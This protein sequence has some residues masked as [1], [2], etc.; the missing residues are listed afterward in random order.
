MAFRFNFTGRKRVLEAEAQIHVIKEDEPPGQPGHLKVVLE[1]TFTS[2][3]RHIYDKSDIVMLEAIRRTKLRRCS[4]GT[5][6]E[7]QKDTIADFPDFPNGKEVYYRL[8]IVDPVTHKLKGL[9]KTLKDADREQKPTDVESLL[10]VERSQDDDELGNLFWK[11][12]FES[13]GPVLIISSKKFDSN[14]LVKS[15]E[16]R[17]LV[18]PEVLREVLIEAF[19]HSVPSSGDS[20]WVDNWKTFVA[21]N[22]GVEG[23]P[24][25]EPDALD[26]NYIRETKRWIDDAGR[27]FA[28]KYQLSTIERDNNGGWQ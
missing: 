6:G 7:L 3:G 18:L 15:P 2:S 25:N 24:E 13:E 26:E 22:L 19:I 9:A 16:F 1:Q 17:A 10:P 28:D 5:V 8:R 14:E 27:S 21:V 11:V 20:E 23:G 4:L 12:K